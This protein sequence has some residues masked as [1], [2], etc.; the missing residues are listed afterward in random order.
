[1]TFYRYCTETWFSMVMIIKDYVNKCTILVTIIKALY[2]VDVYVHVFVV[3]F[4]QGRF[5]NSKSIWTRVPIYGRTTNYNLVKQCC[6]SDFVF[7]YVKVF[8]SL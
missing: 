4:E 5:Y 1:M 6:L 2:L 3:L 7:L 8:E